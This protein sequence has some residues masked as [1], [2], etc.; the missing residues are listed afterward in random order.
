[1][2]KGLNKHL[3]FGLVCWRFPQISKVYFPIG[4]VVWINFL[5]IISH[6]DKE[7]Y[8]NHIICSV[9]NPPG[10][11]ILTLTERW[12]L[13]GTRLWVYTKG[14][15]VLNSLTVFASFSTC[16]SL[17]NRLAFTFCSI[18]RATQWWEER[19]VLSLGNAC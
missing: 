11:G 2:G 19:R 18:P 7:I 10:L 14:N 9:M 15:E 17:K 8:H 6:S 12:V 1:M 13:H 5:V 4:S 3:C 16:F